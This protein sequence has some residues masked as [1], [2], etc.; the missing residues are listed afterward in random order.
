MENLT[1]IAEERKTQIEKVN[2][3]RKNGLIPGVV[4]G[5]KA[6]NR[7]IKVKDKEFKKI[8]KQA[9]ENTLID[10]KIGNEIIGKVIINDYQHDPVTGVMMHFDLYQVRM[11]KK[12]HAK[13]PVKYEGE[14]PAVKNEGGILVKTHDKLEIKCL[15]GDLIHEIIIDLSKLAK[16]DDIIR[17][18]DLDIFGKI[19]IIA[20]PDDVVVGVTPPR[21]E[22]EM[23]ELESKVEENTEAVEKSAVKEKKDEGE[24]EDEKTVKPAE[25]KKK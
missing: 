15:P 21:T 7:T 5:P 10:L 24:E 1:I 6:E 20:R 25:T 3:I 19:E 22:K 16:I 9:G 17:I 13:V 4:Y 8:F 2:A 12:V 14:S 18:K 11:D 23:E